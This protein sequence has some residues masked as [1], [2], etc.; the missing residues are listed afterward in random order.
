LEK[1][2]F[3]LVPPLAYHVY[4]I[5]LDSVPSYRA[6]NPTLRISATLIC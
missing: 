4:I 2:F 6:I 1:L 5:I 3:Q